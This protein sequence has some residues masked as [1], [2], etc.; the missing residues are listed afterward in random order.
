MRKHPLARLG[1]L[2]DHA[3]PPRQGARTG[4]ILREA[5]F[6]DGEIEALRAARACR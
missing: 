3:P 6:D 5:G 1:G 4:E 2:R